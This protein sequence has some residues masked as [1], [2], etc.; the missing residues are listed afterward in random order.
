MKF[1]EVMIKYCNND[2]DKELTDYFTVFSLNIPML[3][4]FSLMSAKLNFSVI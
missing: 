3:G 2:F 1:S 4:V